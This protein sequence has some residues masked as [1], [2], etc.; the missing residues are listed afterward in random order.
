MTPD[1][2]RIYTLCAGTM[3][4]AT[5]HYEEWDYLTFKK[6]A[7]CK[8]TA[9]SPVDGYFARRASHPNARGCDSDRP[10]L[11][12]VGASVRTAKSYRWNEA[13]QQGE[14]RGPLHRQ[15]PTE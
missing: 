4:E 13:L 10:H 7:F 2:M 9:R 15:R 14:N 6:G 12:A 8:I 1:E 11:P 3:R 5:K